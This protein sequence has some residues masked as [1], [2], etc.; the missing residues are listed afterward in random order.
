MQR[1][2]DSDYFRRRATEEEAAAESAVDDRA[3]QSHLDLARRYL[4][5]ADGRSMPA[6]VVAE[7]SVG[8]IGAEFR[9]IE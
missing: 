8:L 9:I 2:V 7:T 4:E 1:L 3:R 6:G 5:V